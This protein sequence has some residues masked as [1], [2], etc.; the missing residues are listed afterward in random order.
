MASVSDAMLASKDQWATLANYIL[1][2]DQVIIPTGNFQVIPVL[3]HMLGEDIFDEL[4]RNNIIVFA[5]YDKWFTYGGGGAGLS[6]FEVFQGPKR[7]NEKSNLAHSYF[8]PMDEA[9]NAALELTT[10]IS[11]ANRKQE[12][13]KLLLGNSVPVGQDLDPIKFRDETYQDVMG[14]PY[15]RDFLSLRNRGR[16]LDNLRGI[17]NNQMRV[18]SPHA[19]PEANESKEIWSLLR[20]GFENF[21]LNIGADIGANEITGDGSTLALLKAK[22]QRIGSPI[23]GSEALTKIQEICGIPDI[24]KA[25]ASKEF[26]PEQ[27]LDLRESKHSQVFRDW[28]ASGSDTEKSEEIVQRYVETI[29]EPSVIDKIPAKILRFAVTTGIGAIQPIAGGAAT[30][31]DSF[32]L[33]KWFPSKSPRLFL[34]QAKSMQVKSQP[35]KLTAAAPKISGRDRNRPCSCGSQKKFKKCC[36]K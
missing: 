31:L 20:V 5:R 1:L 29:G 7:N 9:I 13:T 24:G 28:F 23:E 16:S 17:K 22:G 8:Q 19:I 34:K 25:F 32:V 11:S 18:Y 30:A 2:Y 4:V 36:G 14:S 6:F 26:S 15:L 33:S 35:K 12:L 10:P 21:V 3:R 27:L